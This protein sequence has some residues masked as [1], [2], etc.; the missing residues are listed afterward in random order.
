[1]PGPSE[2]EIHKSIVQWLAVALPTGS[3]VQH[4]PNETGQRSGV[5]LIQKRKRLGVRSGWPDLEIFIPQSWWSAGGPWAP[6]FLEVKKK[7]GRLSP[8]QKECISDLQ[9]LGCHVHT[10]HSIEEAREALARY[11]SLKDAT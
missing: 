9:R 10:V 3:V 6:V 11:V 1:M 7:G 8:A 2:Y 5:G 4:S